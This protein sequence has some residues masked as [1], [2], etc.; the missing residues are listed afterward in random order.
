M[1]KRE[2]YRLEGLK[3]QLIYMLGKRP[4]EF[5]LL[6]DKD[7]FVKIKELIQTLH[8]E[9]GFGFVRESHINEIMMYDGRELFEIENKKIRAKQ[10]NWELDLEN[11]V[12]DLPKLLWTCVRRRAYPVIME[13]GLFSSSDSYIMLFTSKQMAL[14]PGRRKDNNPVLLEI[15]VYDAMERGSQFFR[16]GELF[17]SK[18]ISRDD[19]IGPPL[20]KEEVEQKRKEKEKQK[21]QRENKNIEKA[22]S[23]G[24]FFLREPKQKKAKGK[25]KKGWKEE[26]RKKRKRKDMDMF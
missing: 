22:F 19:I 6:P 5:A 25:K 11:P 13:K 1:S 4:D 10:I 14:R 8:E 15:M 26:V 23:G 9:E 16:F 20:D 7:G 17:L 24:T 2:L 3:K 12:Y 18:W 21:R